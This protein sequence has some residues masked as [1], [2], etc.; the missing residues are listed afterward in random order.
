MG[1]RFIGRLDVNLL[2]GF[3]G[4]KMR[5]TRATVN[6]AGKHP[7]SRTALNNWRRYFILILGS[8]LRFLSVMRSNPMIS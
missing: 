1:K 4:L 5:M 6:C 2:G 8:C 7:L 3:S